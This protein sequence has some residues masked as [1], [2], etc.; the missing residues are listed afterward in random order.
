[1]F[2][3]IYANGCSFTGDWQRRDTNQST[4]LNFIA[5]HYGATYHNAGKPGS[6][7][8]RIIRSTIRDAINFPK[9]TLALVQLTFLHRTEKYSPINDKNSWKFDFEDFKES[10]KPENKDEPE[11]ASYISEFIKQ[12]D[13][14]AE[15][16][17]LM[18]D[19]IMLASFFEARGID[20]LIFSYPQL[21][22][23]VEVQQYLSNTLFGYDL[24]NNKKIL[25]IVN[26]SLVNQMGNGSYYYD[27]DGTQGIIGHANTQGHKQITE[28]LL[29]LLNSAYKSN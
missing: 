7:N 29:K 14:K 20:Y 10:I 19:V 25:N 1:M 11:N 24:N 12:F 26:D 8:R 21:T 28:I 16:T 6:C 3:H 2:K 27:A 17:T 13:E 23:D 9:D 18:A 4:Y 5:D 22:S 15:L